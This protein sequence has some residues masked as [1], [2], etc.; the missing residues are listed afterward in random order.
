MVREVNKCLESYEPTKAGRLIQSFVIDDLSNWFVRLSKKRFWGGEMTDDKQ[1]AYQTLYAALDTVSRLMAPIAPYYADRLYRD[2]HQAAADD[3]KSV[4]LASFP[5]CDES[6]IDEELEARMKMTQQITSM[7]HALRKKEQIAVKQPLKRIAIPALSPE[8]KARIEA[9]KQLILDEVNVK[10]IEFVE[11][12]G[13]LTKKVKCNFRVMGRKFGSRM[14]A[15]AAAVDALSQD[16]IATLEQGWTVANEGALTV[17]LDLEIDEALRLEGVA[18]ELI[19]A[20]Q[21]LRKDSGLEITDRIS[22]TVP[23]TEQNVKCLEQFSDMISSATLAT[24]ITVGGSAL[25][26]KKQ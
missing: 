22:L 13:M 19:R 15:V 25:S 9:M 3:V 16:Q 4:H 5:Q 24:E 17:A 12:S 21:Q 6:A 11:G 20:I 7:I 1:A 23:D 10:E 8:E 26:L 14:K 18:R 2:L